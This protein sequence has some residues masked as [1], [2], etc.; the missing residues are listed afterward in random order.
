LLWSGVPAFRRFGDSAIRQLIAGM[1]D[2]TKLAPTKSTGKGC[3]F[4]GWMALYPSTDG[5][6]WWMKRASSMTKP[7]TQNRPVARMQSGDLAYTA[8]GFHPGYEALHG[9]N[10]DD[11]SNCE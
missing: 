2:H 6:R 4:V 9:C 8:P 10:T 11:T 1:P 7:G 5:T 3:N